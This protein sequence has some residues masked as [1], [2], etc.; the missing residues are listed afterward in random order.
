[1]TGLSYDRLIETPVA[2]DPFR[3]VVVEHF[4]PPEVLEGVVADLPAVERRGSFPVTALRFGPRAAALMAELEGPR[5]RAAIA[6]KFGLDLR[7]AGTMVTLRGQSRERDGKIH[8]DSLAKRVTVLLYLNPDSAAGGLPSAVARPGRH[9]GFRRG[10]AAGERDLAG[11][12]ERPQ[13]VPWP[14]TVFGPALRGAA[15][16]Y[17]R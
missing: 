8:T 12:S 15:E 5:L 13:H 11:V 16:L 9:R 1:M 3:H 10:S 2:T 14:Q 4:V 6:E 17:D 7:D